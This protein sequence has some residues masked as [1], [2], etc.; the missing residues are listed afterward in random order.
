MFLSA[1]P[2]GYKR[3]EWESTKQLNYYFS[4]PDIFTDE[5]LP[6]RGI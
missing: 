2:S 5:E 3:N 1:L 6:Q 4:S